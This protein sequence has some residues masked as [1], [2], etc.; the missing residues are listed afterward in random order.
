M[1]KSM[2]KADIHSC[3]N[4]AADT[5]MVFVLLGR[6]PA[7]PHAIREWAKERIRLGKD[8]EKDPKIRE[9]MSIADVMDS[10]HAQG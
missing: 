8:T 4:K 9:A 1:L 7:A 3:W 10:K 5:E 2:E 6:D